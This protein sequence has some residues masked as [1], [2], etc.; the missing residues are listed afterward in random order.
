MSHFARH[1]KLLAMSYSLFVNRET[2]TTYI[3]QLQPEATL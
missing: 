2:Q 3:I 1:F